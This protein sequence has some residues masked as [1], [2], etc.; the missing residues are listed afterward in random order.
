M[1][2]ATVV[3]KD[4]KIKT[5]FGTGC[6]QPRSSSTLD[7]RA[8]D[9]SIGAGRDPGLSR[10]CKL[11]SEEHPRPLILSGLG[12]SM[13]ISDRNIHTGRDVCTSTDWAPA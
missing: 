7:P 9:R 1:R 3:S 11:G 5:P 13:M 4:R 6:C 10:V 12:R 2:A 8:D